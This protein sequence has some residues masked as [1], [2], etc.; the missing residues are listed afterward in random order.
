SYETL[1]EQYHD[2]S[3]WT[4]NVFRGGTYYD[5]SNRVIK[6]HEKNNL[7]QI[8]VIG[9]DMDTKDVDLYVLF[10]AWAELGLPWPNVILE[11][12]RGYQGFF[13]LETPFFIHKQGTYKSLRVAER[14][15]FNVLE[16]LSDYAPIA[17]NCNPF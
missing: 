15:V 14:I 3:H 5:F 7:K 11:T 10:M 13:I 6:G 17:T 4:P 9:F 2:L 8:N 1:S 12:P 16:A